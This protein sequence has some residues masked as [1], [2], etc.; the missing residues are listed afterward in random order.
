MILRSVA[1][2]LSRAAYRVV[3]LPL[4]VGPVTSTMPCGRWINPWKRSATR[5]EKPSRSKGRN[6]DERS[7][8]RMTIDSPW[9]VGTVETRMSTRRPWAVTRM[10]PS[11]GRRRSAMFISAMILMRDVSAACSPRGGDS[12]S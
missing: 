2:I 9:M 4:P 12:T 5:G 10:R 7:S 1:L 8:S 6:T 11:C 3:V